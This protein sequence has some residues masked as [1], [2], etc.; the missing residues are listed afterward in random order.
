M[1]VFFVS[2]IITSQSGF[3]EWCRMLFSFI[4]KA[5]VIRQEMEKKGEQKNQ[6]P[7]MG[8]WFFII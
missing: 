4:P 7:S 6:V 2:L 8:T 3:Q 1:G 5:Y